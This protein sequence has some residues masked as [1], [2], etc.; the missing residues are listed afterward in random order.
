MLHQAA[1]KDGAHLALGAR[2]ALVASDRRRAAA[3]FEAVAARL[4]CELVRADRA[5]ATEAGNGADNGEDTGVVALRDLYLLSHANDLVGSYGSTLTLS[6]HEL[7][8]ARYVPGNPIPS[9][10]YCL[11][12]VPRCLP[13]LPLVMDGGQ[14]WWHMSL[15]RWPLAM[16][17]THADA[18]IS[19]T[20]TPGMC[21]AV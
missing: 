18:A 8:A 19:G 4:K 20:G 7:L 15:E 14:E 11:P 1:G 12:H 3:A 6:A 17:R 16:L 10:V 2:L 9:V 13:R 5:V 21:A